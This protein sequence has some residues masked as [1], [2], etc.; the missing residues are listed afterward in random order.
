MK[1]TNII[2]LTITTALLASAQTGFA[3]ETE[4]TVAFR[5][6][7]QKYITASPNLSLDLSGTKVGSKQTFTLIDINGGELSDGDEV[8]VRY[9]PGVAEGAAPANPS[10]WQASG[11][12]VK[13]SGKVS[14][15]KVKK[16]GENYA[17]QTLEGKFVAAPKTEGALALVETQDA[18]LVVELVAAKAP[19]PK[20]AETPAA[21]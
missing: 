5:T 3:Q 2:L 8:K 21:Q 13:R 6:P 16:V 20:K 10:Y 11:D 1:K 14:T 9:T 17:F 15:L 4:R 7:D 19:A 18:G 12:G